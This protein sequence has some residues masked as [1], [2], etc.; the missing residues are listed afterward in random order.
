MSTLQPK[1]NRFN[2]DFSFI[3][4][5]YDPKGTILFGKITVQTFVTLDTS[6]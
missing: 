2:S 6:T 5:A 3:K 1:T 4:K